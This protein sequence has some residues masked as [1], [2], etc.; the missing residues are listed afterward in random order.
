[1]EVVIPKTNR[2]PMVLPPVPPLVPPPKDLL[3]LALAALRASAAHLELDYLEADSPEVDLLEVEPLELAHMATAPLKLALEAEFQDPAQQEVVFQAAA[4]LAS[5]AL[6][7]PQVKRDLATVWDLLEKSLQMS[8][9][10]NPSHQQMKILALLT[11]RPTN[12]QRH[13][14]VETIVY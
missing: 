8:L 10:E 1:M 5:A 13:S 3:L 6:S 9:V 7:N 2:L 4:H 11:K 12:H 14:E